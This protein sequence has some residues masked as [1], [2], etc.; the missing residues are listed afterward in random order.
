ADDDQGVQ[1][2]HADQR[3]P[4]QVGLAA[5]DQL[6]DHQR[7]RN[8]APDRHDRGRELDQQPGDDDAEHGVHHQQHQEDHDHEQ[9]AG[10]RADH[11]AG[12]GADRAG[13]VPDAGPDGTGIV[14]A[15]EE[16]RA[17]H[18]PQESRR[19]APDHGNG[20]TD[21]GRG[22]GDRREMVPPEDVAVGRH[23]VDA[24][25]H[26]VCRRA[27]VRIELEDAFGYEFRID[28]VSQGHAPDTQES[29]DNRAHGI[30]SLFWLTH[31]QYKGFPES[32][33]DFTNV[34]LLI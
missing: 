12:Y 27:V 22:T 5:V 10:P 7:H 29:N 13:T 19:P 31:R 15:G 9:A 21:D 34:E 23:E 28:E 4:E 1:D 2:G 14:H 17:Q 16:D 33:T 26:L 32:A 6:T 8:R 18:H 25:F 30:P 11:V 24:V 20:R 3:H